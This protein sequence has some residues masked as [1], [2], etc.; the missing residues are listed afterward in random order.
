MLL[1][2]S[3]RLP[4]KLLDLFL[5]DLPKEGQQGKGW[6]LV[7][8]M[9]Q[10]K[11]YASSSALCYGPATDFID[12]LQVL[13]PNTGP[14]SICKQHD[15]FNDPFFETPEYIQFEETVAVAVGAAREEDL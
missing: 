1:R 6:C 15:I 10:G 2:Q 13:R 14:C 5:L 8:A 11:C 3:N 12:S 4:L 9:D 7:A